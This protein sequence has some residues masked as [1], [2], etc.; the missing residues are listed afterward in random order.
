MSEDIWMVR[1][2]RGGVFAEDFIEE[3]FVS[4]GFPD[5]GEVTAPVNKD[6]V[7]AAMLKQNPKVKHG[8]AVSQIK[9]FYD[10][11][12]VGDSVLTYDPAQRL[13]FIGTVNS[14]VKNIEHELPRSREV[15]WSSQVARESLNQS[16]RNSLGSIS[17][18]FK[19]RD[20][21]AADILANVVNLGTES[22]ASIDLQEDDAEREELVEKIESQS[23][24]LL[25]DR[26]ASL[27]WE[28]MQELVAELLEAMGFKSDVSPRGSDRG[29]DVFA[30]PD[31]C[32][33]YTSDAADE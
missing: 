2:G 20:E 15:K 14:D 25:E 10:D 19:I 5:A 8:M 32:L 23:Q 29:V 11:V 28:Q 24:E 13:Y 3:S 16:T 22:I 18:L 21:A 9:R 17:T 1:A 4:I 7:K 6:E 12:K 27:D 31:G 30:S 26:I 33:L